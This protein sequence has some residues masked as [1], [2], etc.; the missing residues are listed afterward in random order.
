MKC[1]AAKD[2]SQMQPRFQF[3]W[4]A[5][6]GKRLQRRRNRRR[7]GFDGADVE[8]RLVVPHGLRNEVVNGVRHK[9]DYRT[10]NS[11]LMR[12][13]DTNEAFPLLGSSLFLPASVASTEWFFRRALR[14]VAGFSPDAEINA[15]VVL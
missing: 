11:F 7:N 4:V 10:V 1:Y 13:G 2:Q 14:R 8:R 6:W 15:S 12:V 3:H 5:T 9:G